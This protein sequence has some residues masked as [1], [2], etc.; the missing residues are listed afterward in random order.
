VMPL[1]WNTS[2][3]QNGGGGR[4][5][6]LFVLH[7]ELTWKRLWRRSI[8]VLNI[9][10]KQDRIIILLLTKIS[11]LTNESIDVPT[12]IF[13]HLFH[14]RIL[15]PG[16]QCNVLWQTLTN[17]SDDSAASIIRVG[18]WSRVI[19]SKKT[20]EVVTFGRKSSFTRFILLHIYTFHLTKHRH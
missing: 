15:F 3:R 16:R 9:I 13:P 17:D 7:N 18:S 6:I 12:L 11:V 14:C 8:Y 20:E 19:S 5:V 10:S 2:D 4:K 1:P